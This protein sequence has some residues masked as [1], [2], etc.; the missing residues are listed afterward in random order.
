MGIKLN[1]TFVV[2]IILGLMLSGCGT[3]VNSVNQIGGTQEV[4]TLIAGFLTETAEPTNTPLSTSTP[5]LAIPTP[6]SQDSA[7]FPMGFHQWR[8]EEIAYRFIAGASCS[9]STVS[10]CAHYEII[11]R[12]GCPSS[13]YVEVSFTD[14]NGTQVDWSNA[15]ATSLTAGEKAQL[16]FVSF[17]QKATKVKITKIDCY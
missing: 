3:S 7:W 10:A 4:Q 5:S 11:T 6:Y 9:Y 1:K 8:L 16:E 17:K 2:I 15:T 12:D 14:D 13:L